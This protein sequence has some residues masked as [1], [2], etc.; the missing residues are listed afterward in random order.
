[1]KLSHNNSW[2][3]A[4]LLVPV[5]TCSL[6]GGP[7]CADDIHVAI[8]H[9]LTGPPAFIGVPYVDGLTM[10]IDQI[11]ANHL[12]GP[13]TRIVYTRDDDAGDRG[14]AISLLTRY[15][16]DPA[17]K[18]VLATTTGTISPASAAAAVDL[19]LPLLTLSGADAVSQP[20]PWAFPM[21]QPPRATVPEMAHFAADVL[22]VKKCSVFSVIESETYINMAKFFENAAREAGIEI[23]SYEGIKQTDIDF[24]AAAVKVANS[25]IDCVFLS[26]P[27]PTGANLVL[28]LRQ[29][30]LDPQVRIL[31]HTA[32]SSP[33]FISMGGGAV[34]G[35]YLLSEFPP[36][37]NDEAG[38]TFSEAYQARYGKE[39]DNWAA[40]GYA[41]SQI[42]GAALK[43][44]GADPT[45]EAVQQAI[46]NLQDVPVIVGSG[47]FNFTEDRF[48]ATGMNVLQVS[49]GHLARVEGGARE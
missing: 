17:V 29:S 34:E 25:D 37:G 1:M 35:V 44:A 22:G 13:E 26:T 21:T 15:A 46:A 48:A 2:C 18:V 8:I 36:G 39:A 10:G 38:Q 43:A 47:K 23:A 33:D 31:G 6:S 3:Y 49:E 27:A 5:V 14:Q 4:S 9:S 40:I 20:A 30:G 24:S 16:S 7:A 32:L 11:N 28:Q 42:L 41:T 12:L 19:K 45:R